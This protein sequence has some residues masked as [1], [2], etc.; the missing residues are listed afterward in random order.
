[1][2]VSH[3]M[4]P[5][6]AGRI[7]AASHTPHPQSTQQIP[8][9]QSPSSTSPQAHLPSQFLDAKKVGPTSNSNR[10]SRQNAANCPTTCQ[11][12]H[13]GGYFQRTSFCRMLLT[14]QLYILYVPPHSANCPPINGAPTEITSREPATPIPCPHRSVNGPPI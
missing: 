7:L 11:P 1:M 8:P 9:I 2:L 12:K 13:N 4:M 14:A 6:L 10:P 3:E 5:L